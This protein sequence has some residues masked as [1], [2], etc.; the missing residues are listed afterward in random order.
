M[1]FWNDLYKFVVFVI[2]YLNFFVVV[3]V[4]VCDKNVFVF[5]EIEICYIIDFFFVLF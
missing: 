5:G 4:F 1:D 3:F 2:E